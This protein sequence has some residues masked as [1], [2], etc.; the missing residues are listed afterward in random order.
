MDGQGTK[1]RRNIAENFNRL[2][3]VHE[4]Y[5]GRRQ[6]T[7]RQTTDGQATVTQLLANV[8]FA[9]S[10]VTEKLFNVQLCTFD[11]ILL[12]VHGLLS[13][14]SVVSLQWSASNFLRLIHTTTVLLPLLP[15]KLQSKVNCL[16][17]A[18]RQIHTHRPVGSAT[19][20]S[21]KQSFHFLIAPVAQ[22]LLSACAS[23]AYV[24][25]KS[26]FCAWWLNCRKAKQAHQES[27]NAC[28][29]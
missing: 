21:I 28:L 24:K 13:L 12:A 5:R 14:S 9:K 19:G 18:L 2:S 8:N 16:A 11:D 7:D 10:R 6:T 26:L 25:R 4:R 23:Q 17:I 22:D 1:R 20:F 3:R 29:S 15:T 27:R